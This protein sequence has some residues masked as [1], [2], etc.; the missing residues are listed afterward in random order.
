MLSSSAGSTRPSDTAV[1]SS[2]CR[3]PPDERQRTVFSLARIA[4]IAARH[5][6][7]TRAGRLWGAIEAEEARGPIGVWERQRDELAAPVLAVSGAEFERGRA[8]GRRLTL[9]EAVAYALASID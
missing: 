2:C 1:R 4:G 9:D 5:E 8:A 3:A 7:S 6:D